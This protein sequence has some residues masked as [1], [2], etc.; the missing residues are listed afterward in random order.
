MLYVDDIT[1]SRNGVSKLHIF[2]MKKTPLP[3]LSAAQSSLRS[4]FQFLKVGK[5]PAVP[6]FH[7]R[8]STSLFSSLFV[9]RSV[10]GVHYG[11]EEEISSCCWEAVGRGGGG[12]W[13][14]SFRRSGS[15]IG[16][17]KWEGL[18]QND[19]LWMK[20]CSPLWTGSNSAWT[21][22]IEWHKAAPC[23]QETV[24]TQ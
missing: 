16:A 1:L 2:W 13:L 24:Q 20:P 3:F 11:S 12:V 23:W 17:L 18:A 7:S 8:F 14:W 9:P 15:V 22:K 6:L 10:L 19:M 5:P 21:S 4:L